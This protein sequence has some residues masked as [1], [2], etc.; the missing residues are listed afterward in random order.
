MGGSFDTR[1]VDVDEHLESCMGFLSG[2]STMLYGMD[3]QRP[4]VE[5]IS[6]LTFARQAFGWNGR[7]MDMQ[8][9]QAR[10]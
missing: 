8:L 4:S 1:K 3:E 9:Q 6:A 10:D 7:Y 2:L 5:I